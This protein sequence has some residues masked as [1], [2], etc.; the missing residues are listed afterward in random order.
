MTIDAYRA[1]F[2]SS[3]VFGVRKQL[4]AE[5]GMDASEAEAQALKEETTALEARVLAQRNRLA[6]LER[7]YKERRT[8]DDRSRKE[9][10]DF[11]AHQ[12]KHLDAFLRAMPGSNR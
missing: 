10:V 12:H 2:E 7:R 6:V 5:E 3:I 11:L 9:E 1:L 4:Q 8:L